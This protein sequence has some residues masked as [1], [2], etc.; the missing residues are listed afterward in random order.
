MQGN[1]MDY[2]ERQCDNTDP[3]R[4]HTF[5]W[6]S[7]MTVWCNGLDG[8]LVYNHE[9]GDLDWVADMENPDG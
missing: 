8:K 3:H 4:E 1:W 7:T 2:R 6:T 5:K 9:T